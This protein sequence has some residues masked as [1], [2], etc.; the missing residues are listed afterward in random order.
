[1]HRRLPRVTRAQCSGDRRPGEAGIRLQCRIPLARRTARW[2]DR[3]RSPFGGR[4]PRPDD[5]LRDFLDLSSELI[6]AEPR[7]SAH[8]CQLH[9]VSD[10]SSAG[11]STS[12]Y[13]ALSVLPLWLS[14]L[15]TGDG[16]A[17]ARVVVEGETR[18]ASRAAGRPRTPGR[19]AAERRARARPHSGSF[20][21]WV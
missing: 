19:L 9:C 8:G 16:W 11:E 18:G 21:L 1:M 7:Q 15:A 20:S 5:K 14:F 13:N 10:S 3:C 4:C 12:I 6:N 17:A 2:S